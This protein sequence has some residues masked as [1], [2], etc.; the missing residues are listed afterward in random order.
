MKKLIFLF[1]II[2][3]SLFAQHTNVFRDST[4]F[5]KALTLAPGASS[6]KVL[7]SD[8]TGNATWQTSVG[9][10]SLV[11]N[12]GTDPATNFVGTV[13]TAVLN[14]RVGN[15]PSGKIDAVRYNLSYGQYSANSVTTGYQNTSIGHYAAF[16]G[17]DGRGN[18]SV[19]MGAGAV[20][21]SGNGNT[22]IGNSAGFFSKGNGNVCIGFYA[23]FYGDNSN[24][25]FIHNNLTGS[26]SI[27]QER[28]SLI[29]GTFGA[30][31][32]TQNVR[33]N[34]SLKI[35]DGTQGAG[36]VLT[37]DA[38]GLASWG[39]T[40]FTTSD[41]ATIYALTPAN[42]TSYFCSDCSGDG[43]TGRIVSYFSSFWKR[44]KF[45]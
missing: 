33:I 25:F 13:D 39:A 26:D 37:S 44:L 42:G 36:K 34:G 21:V 9:G 19:G 18:V 29:T 28:N 11:G 45:D 35:S 5:T 30:D 32:S 14:F 41:S 10:W 3:S 16:N 15:I 12:A 38:N 8:A 43:I 40:S 31:S 23:G 1:L 7:T 4:V 27:T 17:E 24:R 22:K 6:G 2:N 20:N